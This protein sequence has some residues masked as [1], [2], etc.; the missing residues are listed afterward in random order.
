MDRCRDSTARDP[1]VVRARARLFH[2][3]RVD[4]EREDASAG[5]T[6]QPAGDLADEAAP[7]HGHGVADS[8]ARE[9]DPVER[10]GGDRRQRSCVERNAFRYLGDQIRRHADDLGVVGMT[11]ACACDAVA[12]SDV[13]DGSPNFDH[14]S[15]GAVPDGRLLVQLPFHGVPGRPQPFALSSLQHVSHEIGTLARFRKQRLL[16]QLR[17]RLL[18]PELI[19]EKEFRTRTDPGGHPGEGTSRTTVNPD[20]F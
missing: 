2:A 8:N 1:R 13:S 17:P 15:C 19:A 14:R 7:D 6:Q 12:D 3:G 11:S 10:Y 5:R 9:P 20:R 18:G 4:V 16:G